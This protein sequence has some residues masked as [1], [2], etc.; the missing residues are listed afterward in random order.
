MGC[1]LAGSTVRV[2]FLELGII[3]VCPIQPLLRLQYHLISYGVLLR[4]L[5]LKA[6]PIS[7]LTRTAVSP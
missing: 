1:R 5:L 7:V 6:D 2:G 4:D 3:P